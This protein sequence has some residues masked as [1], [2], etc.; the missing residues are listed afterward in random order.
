[1]GGARAGGHG[2]L[3][4]NHAV[5]P[6]LATSLLVLRPPLPPWAG[7]VPS[8]SHSRGRGRGPCSGR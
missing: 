5:A 6:L 3:A 2:R 7:G 8:P 4:S 1:V